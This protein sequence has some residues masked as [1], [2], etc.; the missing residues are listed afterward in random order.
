MELQKQ[1][2]YA[3]F[4]VRSGVNLQKGQTLIIRTTLEGAP[5]ARLCAEAAY[6]AGAREVVVHYVD[7]QLS[8]MRMERTAVGVLEDVKPWLLASYMDY[9]TEEGSLC[10]LS[11]L[12][13]DP[14]LYKGIDVE[15]LS[16]ADAA[17]SKAIKPFRELSMSNRVQWCVIAIPSTVWAQKVFP[18]ET[19]E[20]AQEKLWEAIMTASRIAEGDPVQVWKEH[21][22]ALEAHC[23]VLNE[24]RFDALH[25]RSQNG[26]DLTVGLADDHIW[27]GGGDDS[28]KG[29]KFLANVPTE[30]VFTAPHRLRTNGVV[31]SSMPY[32]FNG[33]LIEGITARF[34]NG[35]AVEYSAEKNDALLQ[36]MLDTDEGA[37]HIG[38]IALV[39]ASS[40]IRKSG[41]LFYNTLFDENAACHMAFGAGYPGTVEGGGSM[42]TE[43]LL[44]K[45]VNDSLIHEDVMIGTEDM[46]IDGITKTGERV[47]VFRGGEWAL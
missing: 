39:P 19:N 46:D 38:E 43:Q 5:F 29:I 31:K 10:T 28:S 33:N 45:G 20:A 18:Q 14:E 36:Q 40:P 41:I 3:E 24:R 32:V 17:A 9:V 8:R 27:S 47:P 44:E 11:I 4:A 34:E 15:K 21:V 30:E 13:R 25:L 42:T 35:V 37:K 7:E 23:A 1:K 2:M 12:A 22:R 26:T 6:D 16:R